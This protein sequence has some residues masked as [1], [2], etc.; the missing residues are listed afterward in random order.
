MESKFYSI[1][2]KV[3]ALREL[4]IRAQVPDARMIFLEPDLYRLGEH[5]VDPV[6][7]VDPATGA[8]TD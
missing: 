4:R 7:P 2:H 3:E 5:P 1:D 8:D 6:D